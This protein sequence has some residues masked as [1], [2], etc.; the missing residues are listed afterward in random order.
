MIFEVNVDDQVEA[1]MTT[2][3]VSDYSVG[4]NNYR[5]TRGD[6]FRLEASIKNQFGANKNITGAKVWFTVKREVIDF[7]T[8]AVFRAD[9]SDGSG[10]VVITDAT[11]GRVSIR[12]PANKTLFFPDT[13]VV[14]VFDV[15]ILDA[16]GIVITV[17]RGTIT[18]EPDVTRTIA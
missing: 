17:E 1:D 9:S 6:T 7:D 12:M 8:M 13:N 16:S 14:L 11:T 18:V 3:Y 5:M 10:D 4:V 2:A 15:Q